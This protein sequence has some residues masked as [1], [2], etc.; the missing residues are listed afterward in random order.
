MLMYLT[1]VPGTNCEVE[2]SP[3]PL[4]RQ[5][6]PELTHHSMSAIHQSMCRLANPSC[7]HAGTRFGSAV[8]RPEL[9]VAGPAKFSISTGAQARLNSMKAASESSGAVMW[10]HLRMQLGKGWDP[11][12][13]LRPR[14]GKGWPLAH[15]PTRM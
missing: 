13:P 9:G 4:F 7:R 6:H 14:I 10:K 1:D 3:L 8:L 2:M 11:Q 12:D 15:S 5:L